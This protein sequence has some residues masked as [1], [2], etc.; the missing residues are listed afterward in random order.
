MDETSPP[1]I[2]EELL[3][4]VRGGDGHAA[5]ELVRALYPLVWSSVRRHV[6]FAADHEDV[7]QEIYMRIFLKLD[8]YK[9][10]QPFEHWASRVCVTTCYDSLRKRKVRPHTLYADLSEV[11][12]AVIESAVAGGVPESGDLHQDLMLGTLDKL[13]DSLKPRE[14]I[15]I[16]LLD[17]EQRSI[18]DACQMTGWSVSK[19]KTTAMR[20][21]RNLTE[22]LRKI[23]NRAGVKPAGKEGSP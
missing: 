15:V 22:R 7:A 4:R 17:I 1:S 12:M 5:D 16:R 2:Q 18:R 9:G 19:V 11:E 13:I 8:Q 23:E 3:V 14:Q 20:A 6:R 21:R 10:V